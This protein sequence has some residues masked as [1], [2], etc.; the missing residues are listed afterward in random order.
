MSRISPAA[1]PARRE[2]GYDGVELMGSEG[3]LLNQFM[4]PLTNLRDDDWGGDAGAAER[5]PLAVAAAVRA[6]GRAGA[7]RRLPSLR[8]RPRPRRRRAD[9]VLALARGLATSV[10]S[11]R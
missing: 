4:A 10:R 9:D 7:G 8:R 6:G 5:F 1:Q 3:Y 11:M 2:L